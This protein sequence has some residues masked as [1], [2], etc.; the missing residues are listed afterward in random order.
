LHEIG[1]CIPLWV[2]GYQAIPTPLKE[3]LQESIP[4][5]LGPYVSLAGL[6]VTLLFC[7]IVLVSYA[8]K[9]SMSPA[10][11]AGA[12]AMPGMYT[13]RYILLGRGHDATEFQ[14]AQS[15]LGFN[16]SGHFLDITFL[17]LFLTGTIIWIIRS[18]PAI[19]L[20]GRLLL[21]FILTILFVMGL[22]FFNNLIFDPIFS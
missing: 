13:L 16:Y 18:K 3:Y 17:L 2:N 4:R 8:V 6:S 22:Q 11:L 7:V 20:F 12:I 9:P 19:R 5:D 21:G 15:A 14:E 10:I 1:H